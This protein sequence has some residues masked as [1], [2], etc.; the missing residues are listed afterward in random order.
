MTLIGL[1]L[2]FAGASGE[3]QSRK[4]A[5]AIWTDFD[6]ESIPEPKAREDHFET[7]LKSEV[8]GTM[9]RSLDVTRLG[10]GAKEA[11]NVNAFD[12]TPDSS[13]FTNRHP[14]RPM[15]TEQLVRGPNAGDPP[16]FSQATV[17]KTKQAGATVGLRV[18]DNRGHD[19]LLKFDP[20]G[21]PELQSGAEVI[22][23]K[24]LHA[25]GYNVPENY[26]A[27][28]NPST[29]AIKPGLTMGSGREKREFSVDDLNSLLNKATRGP[30]GT[31]R[32]LASKILKGAPKGP[33]AYTGLRGD[34]PNDRIPHEDRRELRGLR[35]IASWLNHWDFKEANTLDMYVDEGGR[36]FLRHYLIDFGSTLGGGQVPT[37]YFHGREFN[38]DKGSIFKE[39]MTLGVYQSAAEKTAPI[40]YPSVGLYSADDFKP[41]EWKPSFHVAPFERMT[42]ADAFWA[43]RII[44]SFSEDD[45]RRIVATAEYSN[46]NAA[47]HVYETLLQRRRMIADYWLRQ[48]NPI[49][50]F[51]VKDGTE[52]IGLE[53]RDMAEDAASPTKYHYEVGSSTRPSDKLA[54]GSALATSTPRIPVGDCMADTRVTVWTSR[55]EDVSR[56]VHIGLRRTPDGVCRISSIV[57]Q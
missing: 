29:L 31:Y 52:G 50:G 9:K 30:D 56:P 51:V 41:G 45:L 55:N 49:A 48:V 15:T 23:T 7:Y 13:W 38:F 17:T 19:Y 47:D 20:R 6:F 26:V 12:E 10:P 43:I 39:L 34:D 27:Y 18:T 3:A 16:D 1:A 2:I 35:V 54:T 46:P 4:A 44:M 25:A 24:I 36:K 33:F 37:E 21:Y 40:P 5:K 32:V 28:L 8:T 22:S 14:L 11:A 53:F 42:Q 57:R